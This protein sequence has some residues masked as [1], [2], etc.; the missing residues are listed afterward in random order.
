MAALR[1]EAED[2]ART[3]ITVG[4]SLT[5][6]KTTVPDWT[7]PAIL[8][9]PIEERD[10]ETAASTLSAAAAWVRFADQADQRLPEMEALPR[11]REAFESAVTLGQLHDGADLAEDWATASGRVADAIAATN[12]D[13]D[14]MTTFGMIGTDLG[15]LREQAIA[16]AKDGDVTVATQKAQALVDAINE[17]S[18]NGGL[19]LAGVIFLIVAI[20]GVLGLWWLFRRNQGPP[21]ARNSRPPW[22]EKSSGKKPWAR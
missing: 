10:F 19:R 14:L 18:R 11:T 9:R 5:E 21:W 6:L 1:A 4:E 15:P 7:L 8:T 12:R 2:Q 17:G 22:A 3:A 16:A 13:R 20:I